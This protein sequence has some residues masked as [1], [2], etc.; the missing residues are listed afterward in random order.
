L[1]VKRLLASAEH[2]MPVK[3][4]FVFAPKSYAFSTTPDKVVEFVIH[5]WRAALST[6]D[7]YRPRL[8]SIHD[9]IEVERFFAPKDPLP[10]LP[11]ITQ[12]TFLLVAIAGWVKSYH[13]PSYRAI[14]LLVI[15]SMLLSIFLVFFSGETFWNIARQSVIPGIFILYWVGKEKNWWGWLKG[16]V[17]RIRKT[18]PPP[19]LPTP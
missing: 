1:E 16:L 4:K 3:H 14:A 6:L 2:D 13:G 12:L 7:G 9:T 17:R 18:N 11:I 5:D 19:S 15:V 10:W 8:A